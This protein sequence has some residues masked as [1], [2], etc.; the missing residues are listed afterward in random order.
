MKQII[1][2]ILFLFII[3]S[4]SKQD[5]NNMVVHKPFDTTYANI[6]LSYILGADLTKSPEIINNQIHDL[7]I[8]LFDS[9]GYLID[10]FYKTDL[11][12]IQTRIDKNQKYSIY[13]IANRGESLEFDN[14]KS[15]KE[16]YV[17]VK[18]PSFSVEN[19]LLGELLEIN[20]YDGIDII[21]PLRKRVA[22][23]TIKADKTE[24]NSDVNLDIFSV[25]INSVAS[26]LRLF[27]A[28]KILSN[29]SIIEKELDFN[30]LFDNGIE[31]YVPENM[32]GDLLGENTIQS[33]KYLDSSHP[34]YGVCTYVELFAHYN[35]PRYK[36]DL[37]YRFY[38]G[39][40]ETNN[41]DIEGN[42][43]QKLTIYFRGNASV[44]HNYWRVET[45][46]IEDFASVVFE[47]NFLYLYP[48]DLYLLKWKTFLSDGELP[49]I[50]CSDDEAVEIVD[51]SAE[52]VLIRA[53]KDKPV[54]INAKLA[55]SSANCQVN[56]VKPLI[57]PYSKNQ[58]IVKSLN[59]SLNYSVRTYK[60]KPM[61]MKY[62]ILDEDMKDYISF[63]EGDTT[64]MLRGKI[65]TSKDQ[66]VRVKISFYDY[67]NLEGATVNVSIL[68]IAEKL[69]DYFNILANPYITNCYGLSSSM[70]T[71]VHSS[72]LLHTPYPERVQ[73]FSPDSDDV[74]FERKANGIVNIKLAYPTSV[75][76]P[77][78][79]RA[80]I[81]DDDGDKYEFDYEMIAYEE[82]NVVQK[83]IW[84]KTY[85]R[86]GIPYY[87]VEREIVVYNP[88][89]GGLIKASN[90][91][92]FFGYAEGVFSNVKGKASDPENFTRYNKMTNLS[93]ASF[94]EEEY[95]GYT[96]R[97]YVSNV[98][99]MNE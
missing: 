96:H 82:I 10:H 68:P 43:S 4:C 97:F 64:N 74:I 38:L 76:G 67:P 66:F 98:D 2:P 86:N 24:L 47:D 63:F 57:S 52:G 72:L 12:N 69:S 93:L 75:N 34:N 5:D 1:I 33:E 32:Q 51:I 85:E 88:Q 29:D 55:S 17:D 40:N 71:Q 78:S 48:S 21:I 54:V 26:S 77:I 16:S 22:K 37:C 59:S 50:E 79:I 23:L 6:R 14:L 92:D 35:S 91:R 44:K 30:L 89:N 70:A 90:K 80:Y 87:D 73:W 11:S 20:L 53:L 94:I 41:F 39:K 45:T 9:Y 60:Q 65:I 31:C 61:K 18:D 8:Y 46:G 56:I 95:Y 7:N 15:L 58:T 36:G 84:N 42:T 62:E 83:E 99:C 25:K 3:F 27:E 19:L 81:C 28:N 49:K 13:I